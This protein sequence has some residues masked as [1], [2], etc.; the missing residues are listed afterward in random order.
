MFVTFAVGLALLIAVGIGTVFETRVHEAAVEAVDRIQELLNGLGEVALHSEEADASGRHFVI[1]SDPASPDLASLSYARSAMR[2]ARQAL[3]RMR[4][5]TAGN[6]GQRARLAVIESLI[7]K[8]AAALDDA[9]AAQSLQLLDHAGTAESIRGAIAAMRAE[10]RILLDESMNAQR[11]SALVDY[12]LLGMRAFLAIPLI[13]LAGHW[14]SRELKMRTA[15][16]RVLAAREE[17]YRQVIELAGDMIFRVDTE[18]RFTFCNQAMLAGLH[19]S[20]S[21]ILGRSYLRLVRPDRRRVAQRFYKRQAMRKQKSTY[22]EFPFVDGHGR[23]RWVGQNVQL[24]LVDGKISGFQGIAREIT[25]RKRAEQELEKSRNFIARIASTTPGILYVYDLEESRVVYSN[26]AMAGVLGASEEEKAQ[27]F[28]DRAVHPDDRS[29]VRSH[30][31]SMQQ[32]PDGQVS[33]MEFRARHADGHWIWLSVRETP[34]ER[35]ADNSVKRVV[36]IAQDATER[37]TNQEKLTRQANYDA[38]TGLANRHYFRTSLESAL[39][40]A[41]L[42]GSS[43]ALCLFDLDEFKAVNDRYGHAAGDEVLEEVGKI[44][45]TELRSQNIA[46]RDIAG[47]LGGDEFCFALPGTDENEAAR[48]AEE[49][50]SGCVPKPSGWLPLRHF[51]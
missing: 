33:R 18:G 2:D 19:L 10:Q 11:R 26:H 43:L 46:G 42:D 32:A 1:D 37:R 16:E 24:I 41:S 8:Q 5:L 39:R 44:V 15:A 34:F 29:Q 21:E 4:N 7:D 50:A 13:L 17:Q 23:E 27:H 20:N 45:R 49:S 31:A 51:R 3:E 30:H 38:L 25:E 47:R 36:G 35:G 6:P 14:V 40:R 48:V 28:S 12:W 22:G 9:N